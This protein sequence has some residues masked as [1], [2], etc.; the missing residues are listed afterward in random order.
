MKFVGVLIFNYKSFL[1]AWGDICKKDNNTTTLLVPFGKT[2]LL[3]PLK[4]RGPCNSEI[5]IIGAYSTTINI[6]IKI[7]QRIS[8]SIMI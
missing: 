1:R 2:C 6:Y 3:N 4:I 8:D 7:Y 5:L